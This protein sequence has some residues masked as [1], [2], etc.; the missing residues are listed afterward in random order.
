MRL[1]LLGARGR[2]RCMAPSEES[3]GAVHLRSETT[4]SKA[5]L[6][7]PTYGTL[8]NISQDRLSVQIEDPDPSQ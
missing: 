2:T 8:Y 3:G 4:E 7:R 5:R 1:I 6:K